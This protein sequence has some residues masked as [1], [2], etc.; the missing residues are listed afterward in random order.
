[1]I[2]AIFLHAFGNDFLIDV[3]ANKN[4]LYLILS[5]QTRRHKSAEMLIDISN[6]FSDDPDGKTLCD[7]AFRYFIAPK[8]MLNNDIIKNTM[9]TLYVWCES[10][11]CIA[12][13]MLAI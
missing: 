3:R 9:Q 6:L 2:Q 1:M 5:C 12:T 13:H 7:I 11:R 8:I 4:W 10:R